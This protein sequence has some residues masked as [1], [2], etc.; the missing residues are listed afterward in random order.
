MNTF[1]IIILAIIVARYLLDTLS[2]ILNVRHLRETLP[3]SFAGIFDDEKYTT[4]QRY[5]RTNTRFG[6][7]SDTVSTTLTLAFLT[8]GGFNLVDQ[9]ARSASSH[10]IVSGLLFVAILMLI[11][12]VAS[13]PFALYDTFV[14]EARFGFN[15]TTPRTYVA[16]YLKGLVLVALIGG[17]VFAGVI[18]FFETTADAWLYVWIGM[19]ALQLLLMFVAPVFIMP[20][21]NKFTPLAE[22]ELRHAIEAYSQSQ[23]FTIQGIYTM[24]GS[25]R[26]AKSNAFFTGFGRSRRIVLFDTLIEKQTTEELVAIVAHEMGHYRCGHIPKGIV[27]A[28]LHTGVSLYLLSFFIGS[29]ELFEAFGMEH[30]SVYAGIVFFGFLYTP[31]AFLMGLIESAISRKHE[32][33][34]DAFAVK[35]AGNANA[36]ISALQKLSVDNLSN[37]TPH[38]LTVFLEYSHPP[39]I[40]RIAAL[41]KLA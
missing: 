23:N 14:I 4:S 13:L 16:D 34:A 33:E 30:T 24:D 5:L 7:I 25:R 10:T 40:E 37:L 15:K 12:K 29:S 35:T 31:I 28:M 2:S 32:Y 26:S 22:G 18:W 21:F 27:R 1:L 11:S 17:P 38:P 20:L 9:V 36:M 39:V 6:I 41:Q 8:L 3:A 19:S